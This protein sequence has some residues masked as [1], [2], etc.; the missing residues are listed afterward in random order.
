MSDGKL[1]KKKLIAWTLEH[2][3]RSLNSDYMATAIDILL[4]QNR[5]QLLTEIKE[6]VSKNECSGDDIGVGD[7]IG[8]EDLLNFLDKLG[9]E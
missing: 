4:T 2:M 6:W 3:Q 5:L 8:Y 7:A 9:K 1:D